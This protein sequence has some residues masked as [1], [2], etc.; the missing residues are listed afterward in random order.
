MKA[1]YYGHAGVCKLLL[2]HHAAIDAL[3]ECECSPLMIASSEGHAAV[4][5]LLLERGAAVNAVDHTGWTPLIFAA[6][7]G[8]ASVCR[9]LLDNGADSSICGP[10]G[11]TA[12][13]YMRTAALKDAAGSDAWEALLR[14][15]GAGSA[16]QAPAVDAPALRPPK[17]AKACAHCAQRNRQL[18]KLCSRCRAV[19]YCADTD[20]QVVHWYAEHRRV[21]CL[22]ITKNPAINNV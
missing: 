16:P 19:R 13:E 1:A 11:T 20:C 21:C 15:A 3:D 5:E 6:N 12:L 18:L 2:D 8:C 17:P 4:C 14:K 9:V 7:K 10:K 22:G